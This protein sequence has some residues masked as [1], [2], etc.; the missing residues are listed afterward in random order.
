[1]EADDT[2]KEL[3]EEEDLLRA[4][5]EGSHDLLTRD[6]TRVSPTHIIQGIVDQM[7]AY[8]IEPS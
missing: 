5:E 6:P 1:V 7:A 8:S 2:R 3:R 4:A